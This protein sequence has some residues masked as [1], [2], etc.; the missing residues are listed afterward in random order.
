MSGGERWARGGWLLAIAALALGLLGLDR[1]SGLGDVADVRT[2]SYADYTRVVIEFE[3][4]VPGLASAQ[5]VHLA[6]DAEAGR[7]ERLYLD[8]P[9]V[10]V[11]LRYADGV[12]IGDGLLQGVRLG[13]N[14]RTATRLVIDLDRYASHRVF[15]LAGPD[16]LVIDV[17][18]EADARLRTAGG[19]GRLPASL[20]RVHTIVVD[21]GHGG[22]DPGAIGVQGLR[23]KDVN[24]GIARALSDALLERG[25]EVILT[26]SE[27]ETRSLEERTAVAE[28]S[29]GDVFISI[30][31]NASARAG[32]RGIE[33]YTLDANHERHSLDVAARENGV[34]RARLDAL[35]RALAEIRTGEVAQQSEQLAGRVHA[36]VIEGARSRDATLPDLGLKKGPFYVLFMS[37]MSSVLVETGFVTN[38]RDAKL[39]RSERYRQEIAERIARG[40][41]RYREDVETGLA[42]RMGEPR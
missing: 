16:R 9:E 32:A 7:P 26:R 34:P 40:V 38:G 20:R 30:H 28:S 27:D 5:L 6:A 25:F 22:D 4:A 11:G 23:E 18:G 10:W 8:L 37:S 29:G 31:A 12:P 15:T 19:E 3:R 1:P 17:H 36:Q 13:Q 41:D 14:T 39:L 42:A 21:A 2:W 35:Q 33:L 24:L